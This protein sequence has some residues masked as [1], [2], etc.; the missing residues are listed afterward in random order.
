MLGMD[1]QIIG[2]ILF[3]MKG[4]LKKYSGQPRERL[5]NCLE[6]QDQIVNHSQ[7]S[8]AAERTLQV[9]KIV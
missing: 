9:P 1:A 5:K 4:R 6:R 8:T 3:L 2:N 7:F